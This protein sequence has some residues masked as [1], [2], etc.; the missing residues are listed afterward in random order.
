MITQGG[1]GLY[2]IKFCIQN[3]G[4]PKNRF[5]VIRMH[6]LLQYCS[7]AV[8]LTAV[9]CLSYKYLVDTT[10]RVEISSSRSATFQ[11]NISWQRFVTT[12]R[13]FNIKK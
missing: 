2:P 6:Q 8:D 3:K 12:A 10:P 1:A 13:L 5:D 4:S 9:R 7:T 11:C